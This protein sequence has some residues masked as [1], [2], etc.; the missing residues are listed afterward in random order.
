M[1]QFSNLMNY[2]NFEQRTFASR[3]DYVPARFPSRMKIRTRQDPQ[4]RTLV[5]DQVLRKDDVPQ[6]K[7]AF[8]AQ[9]GKTVYTLAPRGLPVWFRM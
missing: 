9:N 4:I 3:R 2:G 5:T 1:H 6:S 8:K 7:D